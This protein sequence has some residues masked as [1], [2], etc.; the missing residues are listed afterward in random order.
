MMFTLI[1]LIGMAISVAAMVR[2]NS[3]F[4]WVTKKHFQ[5][6]YD[7]VGPMAALIAGIVFWPIA[8][9]IIGILL[10]LKYFMTYCVPD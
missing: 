7:D 8:L 6:S 3:K 5:T 2:L 1:Y 10:G 9:V 4:K